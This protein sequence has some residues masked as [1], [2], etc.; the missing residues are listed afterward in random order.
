[1]RKLFATT[2]ALAL[3]VGLLA[4]APASAKVWDFSFATGFDS[5]TGQDD[6]ATGQ[7]TTAGAGYPYTVTGISGSFD[8]AAIT[9]LSPY[10]SA[11]QLLYQ[12]DP[13]ADFSG[14]SFTVTGGITYN[15]SN[16]GGPI[17]GLASSVLDPGGY[18][19]CQIPFT[20]ITVSAV[21]EP[22]SL[23]M[24][25]AGLAGLGVIRRKRA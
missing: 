4:S 2:S 19:C 12:A 7:L 9:G 6:S 5:V 22:V 24:L 15:W 8:G 1:M 16:Y 14:L 13:Y 20:S 3:A 17:G 10:A 18:G 21:P 25:G 23:A 11:D